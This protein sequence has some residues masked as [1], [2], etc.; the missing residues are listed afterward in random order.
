MP[1]PNLSRRAA[2][3]LSGPQAKRL[4]ASLAAAAIPAVRMA[5]LF[6]STASAILNQ[7]TYYYHYNYIN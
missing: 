3:W 7:L 4:R 6:G 1:P 5:K 2:F